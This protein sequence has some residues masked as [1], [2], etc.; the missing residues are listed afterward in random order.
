MKH[1]VKIALIQFQSIMGDTTAN[2]QKALRMVSNAADSGAK[3]I[4]LPEMFSTGYNL[5]V[6]GASLPSLGETVDGPTIKALKLLAREK[7]VYII[8]PIALYKDTLPGV[9]YNSAVLIDDEGSVAGTYDK[10]HLWALERFYFR[11][12][13]NYPVFDT[14]Y[15]R[16]GIMICYDAGFPEVARIL[17]CKGAEIIFCPSAWCIEDKDI[18]EL[19]MPQRA[20]ENTCYV[21]A[22]NR[23]GQ[24]EHDLYMGGYSMV[25]NPRGKVLAQLTEE[26]ED[27]LYCTLDMDA[28]VE[29]RNKSPYLRDRRAEQ[30]RLFL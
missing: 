27:T 2:T 13:E 26:K 5:R 22:V 8:A 12:G 6:L 17:T 23:F 9:L 21:C 25:C 15:G 28:I 4:C 1:T 16:I 14:K 11:S 19:N 29:H 24:E 3:I 30:Y 18:W 10:N 20:L 7:K